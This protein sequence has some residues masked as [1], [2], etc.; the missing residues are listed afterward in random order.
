MFFILTVP[1][2]YFPHLVHHFLLSFP[3]PFLCP[4]LP[5]SVHPCPLFLSLKTERWPDFNIGSRI[6]FYL[7][8][9]AAPEQS[10]KSV[11]IGLKW[12][13]AQS[14][15]VSPIQSHGCLSTNDPYTRN[16]QGMFAS[17]IDL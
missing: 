14:D 9:L 10:I 8:I 1:L 6:T 5:L 7:H 17:S 3:A 13:G 16:P 4:S 2:H 11:K 12:C 15:I